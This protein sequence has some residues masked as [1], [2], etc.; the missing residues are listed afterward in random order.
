MRKLKRS[1]LAP[2]RT[3][4]KAERP[5]TRETVGRRKKTTEVPPKKKKK[6]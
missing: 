2:I 5:S 6:N 4:R 1:H 3:K